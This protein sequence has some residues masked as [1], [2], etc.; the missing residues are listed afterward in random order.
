MKL[1]ELIDALQHPSLENF[2]D[3]EVLVSPAE[4]GYTGILGASVEYSGHVAIHLSETKDHLFMEKI[5]KH[6]TAALIEL[7]KIQRMTS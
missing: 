5:Q 3:A 1:R 4:G 6:Q 2:L 7:A